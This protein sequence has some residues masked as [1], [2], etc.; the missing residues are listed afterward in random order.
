MRGKTSGFVLE[1][2]LPFIPFIHVWEWEIMTMT[3]PLHS[4]FYHLIHY[5]FLFLSAFF[6]SNHMRIVA[7][8]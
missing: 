1:M 3:L 7:F 5:I 4:A 8:T 2:F 6:H